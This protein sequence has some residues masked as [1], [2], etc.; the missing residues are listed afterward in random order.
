MFGSP[1]AV[2]LF[3]GVTL[4]SPPAIA[5]DG[6]DARGETAPAG[7]DEGLGAPWM[8]VE[9]VVVYV[10]STGDGGDERVANAIGA[11]TRALEGQVEIVRTGGPPPT[12]A[13][14]RA[15]AA[16]TLSEPGV[17]GVIYVAVTEAGPIELM[18]LPADDER[19]FGA[20]VDVPDGRLSLGL[21][22]LGNVVSSASQALVGGVSIA[23]I[24]EAT[25]LVEPEPIAPE[26]D[27]SSATADPEGP[28][29]STEA[30]D[31]R[32]RWN[33]LTLGA[34][35]AGNTYAPELRWQHG[36]ALRVGWKPTPQSWIALGYDVV[37][38]ARF[39]DGAAALRVARHPIVLRG[40]YGWRFGKRWIVPLGGRI[41]V[42][43][44]TQR[45]EAIDPS[46]RPGDP[47]T[48][49]QVGLGGV[50]GVMVET[51]RWLRVRLDLGA[52]VMLGRN[53]YVV[54][55]PDPRTF[56]RPDP[57]RFVIGLSL[58]FTGVRR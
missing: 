10:A 24:S 43:P 53:S 57:V 46:F 13:E 23:G 11:H 1:I 58:D 51:S 26:P 2:A 27:T 19:V 7:N 36:V 16:A 28:R 18:L 49:V 4:G 52:D 8:E 39:R 9:R 32:P 35:Y 38:V 56:V 3:A 50:T 5:A 20:R 6:A 37:S 22:A 14:A 17:V 48:G 15:R 55:S 34:G 41:V 33:R 21:E 31:G 30:K 54:L 29:L 25:V 12:P 44:T 47:S 42:D 40:G 45:T